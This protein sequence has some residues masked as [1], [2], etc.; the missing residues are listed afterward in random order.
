MNCDSFKVTHQLKKN[1][2]NYD[3]SILQQIQYKLISSITGK[4]SNITFINVFMDFLVQHIFYRATSTHDENR[5]NQLNISMLYVIFIIKNYECPNFN[6]NSMNDP[7]C[8]NKINK[9]LIDILRIKDNE[10]SIDYYFDILRYLYIYN[11][12][13]ND[14]YITL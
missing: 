1:N 14:K 5:F 8:N 7:D 6:I 11:L 4:Y 2:Y 12:I 13:V 10:S 3:K 9:L